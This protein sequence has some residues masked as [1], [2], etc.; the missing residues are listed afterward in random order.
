LL[1]TLQTKNDLSPRS[2]CSSRQTA[3]RPILFCQSRSLLNKKSST[4]TTMMIHRSSSLSR[5][6]KLSNNPIAEVPLS[7]SLQPMQQK[8]RM[9]AGMSPK[10]AEDGL[11]LRSLA[12]RREGRLTSTLLRLNGHRWSIAGPGP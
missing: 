11:Q 3:T 9:S 2:F 7:F 12:W 10:V 6:K 4:T 8:G 5:S 1:G